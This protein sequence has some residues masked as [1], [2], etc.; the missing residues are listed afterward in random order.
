MS[1]N[2]PHN[3]H[4]SRRNFLGMWAKG[5]AAL[6]IWG[7]LMEV[8]GCHNGWEEEE[9]SDKLRYDESYYLELEETK[10][11][12]VDENVLF[13]QMPTAYD[14]ILYA[15]DASNKLMRQNTAINKTCKR[16]EGVEENIRKYATK[17]HMPYGKLLGLVMI[18]SA[19]KAQAGDVKWCYGW[20]QLSVLM[21]KTYGIIGTKEIRNKKGKVIRTQK[22]DYRDKIDYALDATCQY[23][24]HL[25]SLYPSDNRSFAFAAYH[26]GETHMK[27]VIAH[28]KKINPDIKN[29]QD[30]VQIN[31]KALGVELMDLKDESYK[32]YPKILAASRIYETYKTDHDTFKENIQ[33]YISAPFTRKPSLAE[34]YP[35]FGKKQF[36]NTADMKL[37]MENG[38]IFGIRKNDFATDHIKF[39]GIGQYTKDPDE[40]E[41][42]KMTSKAT[43]WLATLLMS[44]YD[45]QL[46]INSLTRNVAYNDKIY[47]DKWIETKNKRT[48]H[49]TGMTLDLD[50]P[51]KKED[52]LYL[53][54]ILYTLELQWK[55]SFLE[56]LNTHFHVNINPAFKQYFESIADGY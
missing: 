49:A 28:A 43:W 39:H 33:Q 20:T 34:E 10:A 17:Y 51:E 6:A 3:D 5:L 9:V 52:R 21:G 41:L 12:L 38:E 24:T 26:M 54:Y 50:L 18:E 56:E 35:W 42:M 25:Q 4:M 7:G 1:S 2:I 45:K 13:E 15:Q 29:L 55:I 30:L 36:K 48:S 14:N 44:H 22:Y 11:K 40:L 19:G 46:I 53:K 32:Y 8:L 47:A 16:M 31:D 37:A 27:K 23:L